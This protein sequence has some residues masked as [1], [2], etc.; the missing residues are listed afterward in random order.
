VPRSELA[1]GRVGDDGDVMAAQRVRPVLR[2]LSGRAACMAASCC[3]CMTWRFV[4][5]HAS[6]AVLVP[7][8]WAHAPVG[9]ELLVR[10]GDFSCEAETSRRGSSSGKLVG[11]VAN[12]PKT[13]RLASVGL[14]QDIFSSLS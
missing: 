11:D 8:V 6:V 1:C 3:A 12:W 9:T 14:D 7:C 10:G 2:L 4:P 13:R 5:S